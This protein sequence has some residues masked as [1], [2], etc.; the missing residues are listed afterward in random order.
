MILFHYPVRLIG[1]S[2]ETLPAL[3]V[4]MAEHPVRHLACI[5]LLHC[6]DSSS[7]DHK[8]S[9]SLAISFELIELSQLLVKQ[10]ELHAD[11]LFLSKTACAFPGTDID[12]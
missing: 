4:L 10:R 11:K 12:Q 3:T 1:V 8:Q 9:V 2:H 5:H 6:S 7:H